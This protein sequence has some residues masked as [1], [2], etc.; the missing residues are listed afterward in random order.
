MKLQF[1][2]SVG[3][4]WFR[5]WT[6]AYGKQVGMTVKAGLSAE[7]A[8]SKNKNKN[9]KRAREKERE[10]E[11]KILSCLMFEAWSAMSGLHFQRIE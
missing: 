8:P 11:V 9:K 10:D 2:I 7:D 6:K 5:T 3:V 4:I 1:A